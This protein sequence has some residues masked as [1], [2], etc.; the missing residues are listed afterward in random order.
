MYDIHNVVERIKNTSKEKNIAILDLLN[1]CKL[2]KNTLSS[3]GT[4]G[5]WLKADSL[6]KIADCLDCSVD[7][8]L[9]RTEEKSINSG[10]SINTGNING[11]NN[12][13]MSVGDNCSVLAASYDEM[14]LE[15]IKRFGSLSF[16]DKM[17]IM[18]SIMKK[19]DK[20]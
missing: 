1:A 19:S 8:L 5:S 16:A 9:G 7:Y 20:R 6:A 2:N 15:L 18:N 11:N 13:N 10:N 17:D 3:M 4:R 12:A 14:T